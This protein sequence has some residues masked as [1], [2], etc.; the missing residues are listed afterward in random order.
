MISI[1]CKIIGVEKEKI[2]HTMSSVLIGKERSVLGTFKG[3][4]WTID[5][6]KNVINLYLN[7]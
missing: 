3:E 6:A 1:I 2:G 4:D 7:K 5:E